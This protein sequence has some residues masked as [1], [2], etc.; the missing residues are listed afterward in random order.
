[1]VVVIVAVVAVAVVV[2]I[3]VFAVALFAAA[4]VNYLQRNLG[5]GGAATGG[6]AGDFVDIGAG[7]FR[8]EHRVGN[9]SIA[10]VGGRAP[11]V[12]GTA[13]GRE[14]E[15][16]R[17][18]AEVD[19]G[20]G[21]AGEHVVGPRHLNSERRYGAG[22]VHGSLG[23][24]GAAVGAAHAHGIRAGG[25][26]R[27]ALGRAGVA[28]RAAP[29]KAEGRGRPCSTQLN[30][31]IGQAVAAHI[32]VGRG[33]LQVAGGCGRA[34]HRDVELLQHAGVAVAVVVNIFSFQHHAVGANLSGRGRAAKGSGAVAVIHQRQPGGQGR[35]Q[36]C[37]HVTIGQVRVGGHDVIGERLAHRQRQPAGLRGER[38]SRVD[39]EVERVRYLLAGAVAGREGGRVRAPV[40]QHRCPAELGAGGVGRRR[41]QGC[42]EAR[43]GRQAAQAH[44]LHQV[45]R[46]RR[47][48]LDGVAQH[49][50]RRYLKGAAVGGRGRHVE[51]RALAHFHR[52]RGGGLHA[53]QILGHE[54]DNRGAQVGGRGRP[55]KSGLHRVAVQGQGGGKAGAQWRAVGLQIHHVAGIAVGGAHAE[56]KRL[57]GRE[58]I[59]EAVGR[60]NAVVEYRGRRSGRY[61]NQ[62]V[63]NNAGSPVTY[64]NHSVEHVAR[65]P[66][67]GAESHHPGRCVHAQA[68]RVYERIAVEIGYG[69]QRVSQGVAVGVAGGQLKRGGRLGRGHVH[70]RGHRRYGRAVARAGVHQAAHVPGAAG[71]VGQRA[72]AAAVGVGGEEVAGRGIRM[73]NQGL[74]VEAVARDIDRCH[75]Q[76][77]GRRSCVA[78]IQV[79]GQDHRTYCHI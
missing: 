17:A 52:D 69:G 67:Q 37:Q 28:G 66:A 39:D 64:L 77:N 57:A 29:G 22:D 16:L 3:I 58:L 19:G 61:A 60:R 40:G 7:R 20:V 59:H 5:A 23:R 48:G 4:H 32:G 18:V 68:R 72:Q 1:M 26:A 14:R 73:G 79:I 24:G 51:A 33:Q 75:R 49:R 8:G 53:G 10:Q 55:G 6:V 30:A 15:R 43:A 11:V 70:H 74:T 76:V 50:A 45:G 71:V 9:V 12:G 54:V 35:G 65:R 63:D 44:Q 21:A 46:V 42:G 2:V 25:Q 34:G 78:K 36:H 47:R 13:R 38:G 56:I 27:G 41:R 62:E 31:A